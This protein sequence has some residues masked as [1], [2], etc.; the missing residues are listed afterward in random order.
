MEYPSRCWRCGRKLDDTYYEVDLE[1]IMIKNNYPYGHLRKKTI[2]CQ[3]CYRYIG[4]EIKK[5]LIEKRK[6]KTQKKKEK[7]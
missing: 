7:K 5:Y 4:K 6:N 2:L 1:T 3:D